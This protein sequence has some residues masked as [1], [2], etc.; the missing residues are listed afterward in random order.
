VKAF[1][2]AILAPYI[3]FMFYTIFIVLTE[4]NYAGSSGKLTKIDPIFVEQQQALKSGHHGAAA[5][6]AGAAHEEAHGEEH[7]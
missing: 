5:H 2:Y 6:D 1:K 7:H 4:G 3:V